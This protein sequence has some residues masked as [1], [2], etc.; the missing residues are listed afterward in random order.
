[1]TDGLSRSHSINTPGSASVVNSSCESHLHLHPPHFCGI[2][3]S[4]TQGSQHARWQQALFP[5]EPW[6]LPC[7]EHLI[8]FRAA[9][10][11]LLP[12]KSSDSPDIFLFPNNS[13]EDWMPYNQLYIFQYIV[14]NKKEPPRQSSEPSITPKLVL[15]PFFH[16]SHLL[17][18]PTASLSN[19]NILSVSANEVVFSKAEILWNMPYSISFA[20]YD[21]FGI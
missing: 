6:S 5:G 2:P 8:T 13:V 3:P 12:W 1:M 15:D 20:L 7:Q 18:Y 21:N 14:N 4:T 11:R 19:N 9:N 16:L 17:P 10:Y